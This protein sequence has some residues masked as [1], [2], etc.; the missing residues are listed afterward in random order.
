MRKNG[1]QELLV[2]RMYQ[3]LSIIEKVHSQVQHA[4]Q[5]KTFDAVQEQYYGITRKEV[6][7][8]LQHCRVCALN[9]PNRSKAPLE[10]IVVERLFERVQMDLIGMS[11]LSTMGCDA[12]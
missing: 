7:S 2:V 11:F 6:D 10:P 1:D 3:V 4:G 9:K 8:L 12:Y 5:H